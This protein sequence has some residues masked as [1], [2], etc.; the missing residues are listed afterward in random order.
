MLENNSKKRIASSEKDEK[1]TEGPETAG[2]LKREG[3]TSSKVG[4]VYGKTSMKPAE[5]REVE[6]TASWKR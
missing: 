4:E 2:E 5:E 6:V 3:E 1:V